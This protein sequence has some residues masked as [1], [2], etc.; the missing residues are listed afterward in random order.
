MRATVIYE[1]ASDQSPIEIFENI[2]ARDA[3]MLI[4]DGKYFRYNN[5]VYEVKYS[6]K[7]VV[8]DG[9]SVH[10]TTCVGIKYIEGIEH[11]E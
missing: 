2:S 3:A 7:N 1:N 9:G 10:V 6:D 4:P 5:D 11:T 8:S